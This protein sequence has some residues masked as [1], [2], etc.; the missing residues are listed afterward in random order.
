MRC[1]VGL[2]ALALPATT[3]PAQD[4]PL[5]WDLRGAWHVAVEWAASPRAPTG[6]DLVRLAAAE[7]AIGRVSRARDLLGRPGIPAQDSATVLALRAAIAETAGDDAAAAALYARASVAA[8]PSDPGRAGVYA[9]RGGS[10]AARA[11]AT[12]AAAT[13][14]ARARTL[15]PAIDGWL[16][17]REARVADDPLAA[18]ALLARVPGSARPLAL[19][20]LAERR[21]AGGDSAAAELLLAE[22]G[23]PARA[24]SLALARGDTGTAHRYTLAALDAPDTAIVRAGL[25]L[26]DGPA[27][28]AV[29]GPIEWMA[30]ARA[31]ARLGE[32]ARAARLAGVAV[33]AG[34]SGAGAL[35][36]WGAYLERAGRRTE[37]LAAYARAG[38][39]GEF[40]RARALL[41][42][43]D[44]A[45]ATRAL[46]A[47]AD[48]EPDDPQAP[49]ALYLAA[50]AAGGD[51]LLA[52]V[53]AR[54]PADTYA[55]R[56]RQRLAFERLRRG[57][58]A[59]A[60]R[61]FDAG[62]EAGG[63]D[64]PMARFHAGR[65]RLRAGDPTG[66]LLLAGLAE[67][68]SLGYYGFRARAALGLVPPRFD[69]PRPREPTPAARAL[70]DRLILLEAAGLEEEAELFLGEALERAW[71]D[72]DELLDVAEGL[73]ANG[74][75]REGIRLGWRAATRL[76]LNHPRVLRAVFPWPD[77]EAIEAEAGEFGLDA[78]LLAGLI[79]QESGFSATAR[80]RAG[81]TG[82]MQLMPTTAREVAA[83]L[84]VPWADRMRAVA[85]ASLHVGAAHLSGLLARY[86]ADAVPAIAAYNAGG[87][88]V[89]RWLR[90]P[91]ADDR[92]LF[93]EG[94]TYPET[95]GYVRTVWR[96]R[97]LYF[98]L[99]GAGGTADRE[100]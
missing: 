64:A 20:A 52:A 36:R 80:S 46:Q 15:I 57:D 100:P 66:R 65:L 41:R 71:D 94:I 87:T 22:A 3:L 39:A 14:Y 55:A 23:R 33:A 8:E 86:G 43:G 42:A 28:A 29:R 25:A 56:A 31:A 19:V 24:A 45:A 49:L 50:D 88:P 84:R 34:D 44:R 11:G 38:H 93:V 70:L 35:A 54:W 97:D 6:A 83:R 30:A 40:P 27:A 47:F 74:R 53:A 62:I 5:P 85:D 91:G 92:V 37:A 89:T 4:P 21:L 69:P 7:L 18:Q 60:L 79:R 48:G 67:G 82:I 9:A 61:F 1:A 76:T 98:A 26:L 81:A 73:I 63:P 90:T 96:N 77:R 99:Y 72:A 12:A 17:L 68:D 16:G 10:A 59:A 32:D 78:Y 2:V 13:A 58:T 51:S 95:Q 75:P